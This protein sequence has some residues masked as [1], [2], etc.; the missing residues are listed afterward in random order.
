[1]FNTARLF[2]QTYSFAALASD[3]LS[4]LADPVKGQPDLIH[5]YAVAKKGQ[6]GDKTKS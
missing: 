3:C 2:N 6:S 4:L 1:M 5:N